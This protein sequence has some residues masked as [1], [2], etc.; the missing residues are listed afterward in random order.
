M[1][2]EMDIIQAIIIGVVLGIM[3]NNRGV[4]GLLPVIGNL[5]YSIAIFKFIDKRYIHKGR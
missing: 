5:E 2:W 4:L 3:F 1:V